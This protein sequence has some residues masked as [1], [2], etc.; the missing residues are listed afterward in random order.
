MA[1]PPPESSRNRIE[2]NSGT[3]IA[4]RKSDS[5]VIFLGHILSITLLL[6]YYGT[7]VA[8]GES[9]FHPTASASL[10]SSVQLP[11]FRILAAIPNEYAPQMSRE[12][13][14][15]ISR[16]HTINKPDG[17]N[18]R[19]NPSIS[20][21]GFN[22]SLTRSKNAGKDVLHPEASLHLSLLPLG[23]DTLHLLTHMCESM[24]NNNP[25]LVLSFLDP[26]KTYYM[27]MMAEN[28]AVPLITLSSMYREEPELGKTMTRQVK[29]K[30]KYYMI[31][32]S[33]FYIYL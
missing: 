32:V 31:I 11:Q 23:N 6:G 15:G 1:P 16:W 12:L 30:M 21:S 8:R 25:S 20:G 33:I 26:T 4:P 7:P 18:D 19:L 3:Q 13:R 2:P 29:E 9:N 14:Q 17:K 24:E 22:P 10:I 5:R 27:S 28:A